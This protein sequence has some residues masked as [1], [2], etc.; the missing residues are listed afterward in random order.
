MRNT[1]L[2]GNWKMQG[3]RAQ[4]TAL[5]DA[6]PLNTSALSPNAVVAVFPPAPYLSL[7][8]QRLN[9]SVIGLGAQTVSEFPP[10]AYTGE[11]AA[12]MLVDC[13]CRYVLIGH[14]ERRALFDENDGRIGGKFWRAVDAALIPV[15]CVGESLQQWQAGTTFAVIEQQLAAVFADAKIEQAPPFIVAYEPVWAIGTGQVASPAYAQSVHQFIRA[16]LAKSFGSQS[17]TIAIVYGGSVKAANFVALLAE[18]DIDGGLVG[19]ASW[20]SED[21]GQMM[22]ALS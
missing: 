5:L 6:L 4:I 21:F 1:Y 9:D 11:M 10:G 7:V 13:G 12:E 20:Q 16:E 14:S 15:L 18:P 3:T 17:E 22:R 19:G 2:L 8:Q